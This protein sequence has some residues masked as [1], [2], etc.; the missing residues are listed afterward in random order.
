MV[1]DP[2]AAVLVSNTLSFLKMPCRRLTHANGSP[3]KE[4]QEN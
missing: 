4:Y 2:A 1:K 3:A